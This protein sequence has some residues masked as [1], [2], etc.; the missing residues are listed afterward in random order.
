[1][2]LYN[3]HM[4]VPNAGIY[5]HHGHCRICD[6]L[7]HSPGTSAAYVK[8]PEPEED[9]LGLF[10]VQSTPDVT[11]DPDLLELFGASPTP[12]QVKAVKPTSMSANE[13]FGVGGIYYDDW[14]RVLGYTQMGTPDSPQK[15]WAN[16]TYHRGLEACANSDN[17]TLVSSAVEAMKMFIEVCPRPTP[18]VTTA[19]ANDQRVANGLQ[20]PV[21]AT[22]VSFM[23]VMA[24][25]EIISRFNIS[26]FDAESIVAHLTD[27]GDSNDIEASELAISRIARNMHITPWAVKSVVRAIIRGE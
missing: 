14:Q 13:A 5:A 25:R 4:A 19:S 16:E 26:Q 1:M 9:L 24:I 22:S 8:T 15:H 12:K 10:E 6:G 11:E 3:A 7:P 21:M 2:E 18:I 23:D 27:A 17:K 20:M